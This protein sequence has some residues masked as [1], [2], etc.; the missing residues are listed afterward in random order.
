[1]NDPDCKYSNLRIVHI[2]Y[3][4][5]QNR[6]KWPFSEKR[7]IETVPG[8]CYTHSQNECGESA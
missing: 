6:E 8:T 4:R 7:K 3:K 1:M 5:D 2:S